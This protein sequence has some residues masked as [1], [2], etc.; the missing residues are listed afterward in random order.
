MQ[1]VLVTGGAGYVGTVLVPMLLDN[2]YDVVV[3]DTFWFWDN[4]D[5]Y[6]DAVEELLI[7]K[8]KRANLYTQRGDIRIIEH[9]DRDWET[10][11]V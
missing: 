2:D 3:L 10:K 4:I 11:S 6:L 8:S 5:D 7:D 1:K 9:L